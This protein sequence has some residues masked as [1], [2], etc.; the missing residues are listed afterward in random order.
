MKAAYIN[1]T[2]PPENIIVGDL[3][4]PEPT[5][6]QVLVRVA[7]AASTRSIRTFARHDQDGYP[8][9]V[10]RRLRPGRRRRKAS[11]RMR[12][13][14]KSA[15]ACGAP[16]KDCWAG[17][18]R[19][20]NTRPSMKSGCIPL[21]TASATKRPPPAR[22]SASPRTSAWCA[23]PSCKRGETLFVNGGTGGVGSMVV[24]MA[25]AIGARVITTAGSDEKVQACRELGADAAINYKTEDVDRPHQRARA[26]RRQRLVGNAARAELRPGRRR[27]SPRAAA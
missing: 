15:I 23:T 3:P 21:P 8:A 14:S 27:C 7:A 26:R 20:P 2:G 1:Q 5:G 11:A 17:K 22:S 4:T 13:D 16:T 12:S 10:H 9:A 25:K 24:Q 6:S 18:A 19:S